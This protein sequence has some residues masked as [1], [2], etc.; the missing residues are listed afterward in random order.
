MLNSPTIEKL[1]EMRL[2]V[3]AEMYSCPEKSLDEMTFEDRFSLM[4]EEQWL[5]KRNGRIKRLIKD[6]HFPMDACI[7]DIRYHPERKIDKKTVGA[8]AS[9]TYIEKRLNGVVTGRT[10][11]GYGKLNIM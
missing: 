8:L 2:K 9:C 6:A 10:G 3:M 4:V 11:S 7:E 1:K 5:A